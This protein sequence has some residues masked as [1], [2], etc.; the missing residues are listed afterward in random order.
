MERSRGRKGGEAATGERARDEIIYDSRESQPDQPVRMFTQH[1]QRV[2]NVNA[3]MANGDVSPRGIKSPPNEFGK[4]RCTI[5]AR[6]VTFQ[7]QC[8]VGIG[9]GEKLTDRFLP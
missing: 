2:V 6:P 5:M 3:S 9:G 1:G 4:Y 8:R 7:C